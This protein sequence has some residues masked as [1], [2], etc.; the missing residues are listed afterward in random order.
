EQQ[1]QAEENLRA[2]IDRLEKIL[3]QLRE[4]EM[5]RE[6]ARL[7]SRL[8]KMAQMQSNVLDETKRLEAIPVSQRDRQVDVKAGNLAFEEKKI[9]MEA[10][11]ALLLLREEGSSVAFPE[12]VV[13]IRDDMQRVAE[14]LTASR[15]D[16]V[17][18]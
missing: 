16:A 11:R 14:R 17:T 13:Q 15:L 12:V 4:E 6:L 18:I 2:A 8:R 3:R 1:Q 5:Q 10:D 9:I 7:E